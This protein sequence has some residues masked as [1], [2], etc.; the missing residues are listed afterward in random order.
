MVIDTKDV[1][2]DLENMEGSNKT[3]CQCLRKDLCKEGVKNPTAI[4]SKPV[5]FEASKQSNTSPVSKDY[6]NIPVNKCPPKLHSNYCI[7]ENNDFKPLLDAPIEIPTRLEQEN[8]Y[9]FVSRLVRTPTEIQNER[10]VMPDGNPSLAKREAKSLIFE[11]MAQS[12]SSYGMDLDMN[13]S[14]LYFIS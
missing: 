4:E 10:D 14:L 7:R 6:Y 11:S 5:N 13:S 12:I 9:K 3:P 8:S 2:P 1:N